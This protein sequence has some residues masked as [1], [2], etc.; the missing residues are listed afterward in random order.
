MPDQRGR[1]ADG[2]HP[3][4]VHE[5]DAV[6]ALGLVHEVGRDEDGDPLLAGE[7]Q[8]MAPEHVPRCRVHAGGRFVEDQH[9]G[10]VQAGGGQL[11]S[12][13]DAQGQGRRQR[14]GMAIEVELTQGSGHGLIAVCTLQPVEPGMQHQVLAYAQLLV[15]REGLGH[16]ADPHPGL[17]AAGRHRLPE[18]L[19]TALGGIEQ[20]GQHLHGGRLAT[21][22]G[23]EKAEDLALADAETDAVDGGEAAEAPGQAVGLDGGRCIR[24]GHEGGQLQL[25]GPLPFLGRQQPDVGCL[26]GVGTQ[27]VEDGA[28]RAVDQQPAVVHRQQVLELTGLLDVGGGDDQ[29][30]AGILCPQLTDQRPELA[31]RQRIDPGGRLVEDQQLGRMHQGTAQ[32][33]LLLHAARQLAGRPVGE[34]GQPGGVEQ[35]LDPLPTLLRR[36]TEQPGMEIDVLLYRQ[37]RI[38]VASQALRHEGDMM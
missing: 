28:G 15:Q 30:H 21:T 31:A 33:Q 2:Q 16:V 37:R 11:Q 14:I 20:P 38:E 35:A 10:P 29:G 1:G 27:L 3:T 36:Q 26:Q 32:A 24:F 5:G 9:F 25:A 19:G 6:A 17:H 4:A 34:R 8:Q 22:V 18:Q 13:A 23:A 12:L 7:L